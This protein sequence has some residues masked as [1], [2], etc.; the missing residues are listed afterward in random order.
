MSLDEIPNGRI[1][2]FAGGTGIHPYCDLIDLLYKETLV[3]QNQPLS[4]EIIGLNPLVK[5]RTLT[6]RWKFCLYVAVHDTDDIHEL[7]VFQLNHLSKSK[8]MEVFLRASH[9]PADFS[10]SYPDIAIIDKRFDH[11]VPELAQQLDRISQIYMCGPPPMT[12]ALYK[13]FG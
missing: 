8:T 2:M 10:K 6:E 5:Q 1:V 3:Q 4:N 12:A 13:C 11:Y 9:R 7:T